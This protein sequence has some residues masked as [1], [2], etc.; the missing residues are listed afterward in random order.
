MGLCLGTWPA[1][2]LNFFST[3]VVV[4]THHGGLFP[5]SCTS[6]SHAWRSTGGKFQVEKLHEQAWKDMKNS[7]M[8]SQDLC[9]IQKNAFY[10]VSTPY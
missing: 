1:A 7:V 4:S 6:R 10:V 9:F 2:L 8:L 5:G 3:C